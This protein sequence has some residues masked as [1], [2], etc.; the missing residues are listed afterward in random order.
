MSETPETPE[1]QEPPAEEEKG[2]HFLAGV[3]EHWRPLESL[4]H[5]V[6]IYKNEHV[7]GVDLVTFMNAVAELGGMAAGVITPPGMFTQFIIEWGHEGK[8]FVIGYNFV[9]MDGAKPVEEFQS[10]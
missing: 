6:L 4:P 9:P 8:G 1:T 2:T 10:E 3:P 5:V 7:L